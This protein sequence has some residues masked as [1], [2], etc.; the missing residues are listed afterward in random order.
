M[1]QLTF[2]K[3]IVLR[4]ATLISKSYVQSYKE[5]DDGIFNPKCNRDMCVPMHFKTGPNCKRRSAD[6]E[7]AKQQDWE[8]AHFLVP[9]ALVKACLVDFPVYVVKKTEGDRERV[10]LPV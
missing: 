5:V 2:G 9:I 6:E 4:D 10:Y 3:T 7:V 8:K 1:R